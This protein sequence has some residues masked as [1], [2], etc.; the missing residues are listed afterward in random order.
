MAGKTKKTFTDKSEHSRYKTIADNFYN[1]ALAEK[2]AK[3]WNA[4]GV[5]MVHAA[6]AYADAATIKYGSVKSRGDDH[7]DV[8]RLLDDLL[9]PSDAKRNALHQLERFNRI[10]P[11]YHTVE[12]CMMRWT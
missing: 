3:R 7:Q 8:V 9:P 2:E 12:K 11:V 5:L 10:N 4:S 6:I 1:G